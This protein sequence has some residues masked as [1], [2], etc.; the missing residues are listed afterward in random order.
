MSASGKR[1]ANGMVKA[2]AA[3]YGKTVPALLH[4]INGPWWQHVKTA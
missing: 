3:K 2:L 1:K 4:V